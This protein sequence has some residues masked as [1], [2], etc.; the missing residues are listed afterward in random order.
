M[1]VG[2]V[3]SWQH[4]LPKTLSL[5]IWKAERVEEEWEI[6]ESLFCIS[7]SILSAPTNIKAQLKLCTIVE[8]FYGWNWIYMSFFI[9]FFSDEHFIEALLTSKGIKNKTTEW[10]KTVGKNRAT[11]IS[12][13]TGH[14]LD[15][16]TQSQRSQC[17]KDHRAKQPF[18]WMTWAPGPGTRI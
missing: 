17:V 15:F 14:D 10:G 11:K 3:H 4:F 2:V 18:Q 1:W 6:Q 8:A 7:D 9:E 12:W 5:L 13:V 16:A